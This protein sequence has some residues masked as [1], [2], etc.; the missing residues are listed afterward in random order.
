MGEETVNAINKRS[1]KMIYYYN[2]I[3]EHIITDIES[4]NLISEVVAKNEINE[5]FVKGTV[6]CPGIIIGKVYVVNKSTE[7]IEVEKMFEK[8]DILVSY[9]PNPDFIS[10]I[11]ISGAVV[12]DQGGMTCH[13]A[14]IAR[15]LNIPCIVGTMNAT[16]IFKTGD[17]I[18]VDAY[19]GMAWK[20]E[21][22]CD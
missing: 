15:E 3:Q 4:I 19:Q 22:S 1:E 7:V 17:Y 10:I 16:S 11:R 6:V 14:S 18:T 21:Q 5:N 8:G 20:G 9:E 2:G 12:T 13:V